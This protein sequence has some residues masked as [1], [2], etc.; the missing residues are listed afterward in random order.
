MAGAAEYVK[1]SELFEALEGPAAAMVA[2]LEA[3]A[4]GRG[5]L[6]RAAGMLSSAV[7]KLKAELEHRAALELDPSLAK[8]GVTMFSGDADAR[9]AAREL[10]LCVH[11]P[12]KC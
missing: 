5:R 1:M 6:P 2:T 3:H 9:R 11:D 8:G 10:V 7:A 4:S 12:E